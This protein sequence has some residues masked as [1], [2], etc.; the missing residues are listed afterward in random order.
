M[1][2]RQHL[3]V[4]NKK[5]TPLERQMS[6][7]PDSRIVDIQKDARYLTLLL[8]DPQQNQ[9]EA[10]LHID[11]WLDVMSVQLPGIPWQQ[12]PLNYLVCWLNSMQLS[13]L[14][15]DT[16]W[17]VQTITLPEQALPE[18]M[19]SLPAQPCPLLCLKWPV[20]HNAD[21]ENGDRLREK[22]PFI[23]RYVLGTSQLPLATLVDV[24]V[25]DLLLI[26]QYSP[27]LAIGQR[28]LFTFN[29]DRYQ[30]VIV[31]EQLYDESQEYRAEEETLL[32]WTQLPV[33]IEFV[34]DSRS[35]TLND[36]DD[37]CPGTVLPVS[38]QAEHQVKI[39]LNRKFFGQGEL[40]ALENGTL[41]VEVNKINSMNAR[42]TDYS[43]VE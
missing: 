11:H 36:L 3:R 23:L 22:I 2:L 4:F 41:A 39:Y 24:A 40:V 14:V 9:T 35:V 27:H 37:I 33:D 29:Y 38:P 6:Q 43:D 28:C 25:G 31:E 18:R 10:F 42:L 21:N 5:Q 20:D 8:T 1:S 13:F 17:E 26:K 12:V 16:I 32:Q 30:E 34:L 7:H 15:K 19:L